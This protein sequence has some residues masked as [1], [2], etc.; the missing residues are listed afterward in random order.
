MS[1][2]STIKSIIQ[3]HWQIYKRSINYLVNGNW[4]DYDNWSE[5]S[6]S[7]GTTSIKM[8]NRSC[9]NP[10]P[11][12]NGTDCQ[13]HAFDYVHCDVTNCPGNNKYYHF[14]NTILT[15]QLQS[16]L[17]CPIERN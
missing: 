13:G 12:Y 16:K 6:T 11:K 1:P 9:E 15:I 2:E 8:R 14:V 7:C 3:F 5:C 4:S 10:S 17:Y